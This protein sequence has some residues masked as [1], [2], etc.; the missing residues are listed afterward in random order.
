MLEAI[1]DIVKGAGKIVRE[2]FF[3]DKNIRFKGNTDLVT[4]YDIKTEEYLKEKLSRAFPD[5]KII[6][7]ESASDLSFDNE[8]V[9]YIDPIDGTTNFVHGLPFVAISVGVFQGKDGKC[10][11]VYNPISDE[12]YTGEAGGGA[13]CNGERLSVSKN[14]VLINSLAATGFPYE[15][16]N[17][18]FLM[19]ILET[20]IKNTRGVRRLGAASL[21]LCYT[22]KGVFDIYYETKL[23]PWD[24]AAGMI[25]VR[26]SGGIVTHLN[27]QYHDMNSDS[28]I[29]SNGLI[30]KEFLNLI[31]E[32]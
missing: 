13:Y 27:G 15:K 26:E 25:I 20:V 24:M 19:K 23:K 4:E 9:I 11:A 7:E 21:D 6:A 22:A 16:D 32:I 30:H 8:Q 14:A 17:L 1:T 28:I 3:S 18:P 10:G 2:G 31:N 29:A 5:A 12:L